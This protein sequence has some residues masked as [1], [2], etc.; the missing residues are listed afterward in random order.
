M[1]SNADLLYILQHRRQAPF[2]GANQLI[3]FIDAV[4]S[5]K[6]SCKL[7]IH[8]YSIKL[9]EVFVCVRVLEISLRAQH[10]DQLCCIS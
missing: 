8:F 10:C 6:E 2:H 3:L 7:I 4:M 1:E 9:Q 5:G